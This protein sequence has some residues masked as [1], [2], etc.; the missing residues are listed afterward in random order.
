M[1]GGGKFVEYYETIWNQN[2]ARGIYGQAQF[3][4]EFIEGKFRKHA[5]KLFHGCWLISQ[6]SIDFHKFRFCVF[7]HDKI[8][9]EMA[10]KIDPSSLLGRKDKPF[11]AVAEFMKNAGVGIIYAVPT[12]PAGKLTFESLLDKDYRIPAWH[13][14]FYEN[15]K[16][17]KKAHSLDFFSGWE[18]KRGRATYQKAKWAHPDT[19]LLF[20]NLSEEKLLSMLL[21]ELFVTGYL[22]AILKKP[23]AD[24]YDVD[25]FIISLSQKHILPIELKE[26]FPVLTA[27][28]RFFGIDAGRILMLL[29]ICIPNDSNALYIIREVEPDSRKLKAWKFMTLSKIVMTSGWNLQAGG[30]GMGGQSTQTVKS[31]LR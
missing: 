11:Y 14:L 27:R 25:G 15:E 24:L 20:A 5:K 30:R 6:K 16:L 21:N 28:E 18:G 23:I 1:S 12:A 8:L 2:K 13:V 26:K 19:R 4:N 29:R 22:R 17:V 7:V 3:E 31:S 9:K 10:D